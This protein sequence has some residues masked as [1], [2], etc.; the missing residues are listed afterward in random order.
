MEEV[1][2]K[3][4]IEEF[5]NEGFIRINNAFPTSLA[6]EALSILWKDLPCD[7][8]DPST[9]TTPVI[10]L[11]MYTDEPFIKAANTPI[12]RKAFDQLVGPGKWG[13]CKSMGTFP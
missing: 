11:G 7:R 9:W 12:L 3:K 13:S 8:N 4:Q 5:V 10:R 1:L 6:E 2:D